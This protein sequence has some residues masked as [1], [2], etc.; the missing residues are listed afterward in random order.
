[1]AAVGVGLLIL[2]WW[3]RRGGSRFAREWVEKDQFLG[4]FHHKAVL[5]FWPA[6]GV[7]LIAAAAMS[8]AKGNTGIERVAFA[9]FAMATGCSLITVFIRLP[10]WAYPHW[11]RQKVLDDMDRE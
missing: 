6:F 4:S 1:M 2:S 8:L 5:V 7:I 10:L 3:Q 9:S 11:A